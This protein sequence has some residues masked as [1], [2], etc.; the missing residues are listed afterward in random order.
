VW[1]LQSRQSEQCGGRLGRLVGAALAHPGQCMHGRV[2]LLVQPSTRTSQQHCTFPPTFWP[3][4]R[5]FLSSI[6]DNNTPA[7]RVLRA[8]VI[9]CLSPPPPPPFPPRLAF[10]PLPLLLLLLGRVNCCSPDS[11]PSAHL[12]AHL[13]HLPDT[14]VRPSLLPASTF[15]VHRPTETYDFLHRRAGIHL[16]CSTRLDLL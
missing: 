6:L 15:I 3:G 2:R 13:R 12:Q 5:L 8:V 9:C 4:E 1:T 11:P 10:L 7:P 16:L 14:R